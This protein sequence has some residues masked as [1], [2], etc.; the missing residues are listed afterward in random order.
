[1]K[2]TLIIGSA[3]F[4]TLLMVSTVTAVPQSQSKPLMDTI[5]SLDQQETSLREKIS[6]G[7]SA[8]EL[9]GLFDLI[10]QIIQWL[11]QVLAKIIGIINNVIKIVSLLIYVVQLIQTLINFIQRLID[12]INGL[13]NPDA[14][15]SLI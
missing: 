12:L 13:F 8:A 10:M 7:F 1:M 11:A 4:I 5:S 15:A 9:G 3:L 6:D 14:Q 2:R